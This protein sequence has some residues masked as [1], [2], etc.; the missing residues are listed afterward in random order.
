MTLGPRCT[1][2]ICVY[3]E[4]SFRNYQ[5]A[6]SASTARGTVEAIRVSVRL[7]DSEGKA[8]KDS[9]VPDGIRPDATRRL[10]IGRAGRRCRDCRM[11]R[12]L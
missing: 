1:A 2:T 10:G 12:S 8:E 5:V 4:S 9:A 3:T 7:W 11:V 6:R